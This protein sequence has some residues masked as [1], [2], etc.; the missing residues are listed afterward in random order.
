MTAGA[1]RCR[2]PG[3]IKGCKRF[4]K[5]LKKVEKGVDIFAEM[6]YYIKVA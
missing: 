1:E 3:E 6:V 4:Q 5:N 2:K